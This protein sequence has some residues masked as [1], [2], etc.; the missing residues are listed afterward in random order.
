MYMSQVFVSSAL[1]GGEWSAS[2]PGRFTREKGSRYPLDRRLDGPRNRYGRC[3]EG[4]NLAPTG[5]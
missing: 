1:V 4:K 2:R 3:G 5:T